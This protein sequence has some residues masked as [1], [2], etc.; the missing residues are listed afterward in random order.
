[1]KKRILLGVTISVIVSATACSSPEVATTSSGSCEAPS[2]SV[3]TPGI[4][5]GDTVEISGRSFFDGCADAIV[6]DESGGEHKDAV[7]P[8]SSIPLTLE[9][10]GRSFAL[11][12][13][14]ADDNGTWTAELPLPSEVV[15]GIATVSAGTAEPV[16]ISISPAT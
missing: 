16:E 11:G 1:M 13:I 4:Q 5:I 7:H 15:E 10:D 2:I 9:Q 12:T 14:A 6:V 3:S 8:L